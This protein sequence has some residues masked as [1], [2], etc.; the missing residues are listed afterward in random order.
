MLEVAAIIPTYNSEKYIGEAIRSVLAQTHRVSEIIVV[1][2]GS[3][4]QTQAVVKAFDSDV[5]LLVNPVNKGPGFSRNLGVAHSTAPII[6]FLDS[7]DVWNSDHIAR[8]HKLLIR[9]PEIPLVFGPRVGFG[10][11]SEVWPTTELEQKNAPFDFLPA[12]L[13]GGIVQTST[14]VMRKKAFEEIGGFD[15]IV[16]YRH[17]RRVQAEDLDL[18]L[19]LSYHYPFVADDMATVKYRH[20]DEQSSTLVLDQLLINYEYRL[21]FLKTLSPQ[22]RQAERVGQGVSKMLHRWERMLQG[23]WDQ[24]KLQ[25]LIQSLIFG[26]KNNLLRRETLRFV[27]NRFH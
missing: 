22:Q 10:L 27:G 20:H 21:R 14:I 13:G 6:A 18:T 17:G 5:R 16:R 7:D 25:D 12:Q 2:D 24:R 3:T 26:L 1:D 19:K 11:K 4:D 23:Y 15:D 8:K 9:Y